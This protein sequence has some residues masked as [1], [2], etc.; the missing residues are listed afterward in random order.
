MQSGL[1]VTHSW[2]VAA[3]VRLGRNDEARAVAR[4]VLALQP[5]F[6]ASRFCAAIGATEVVTEALTETWREAGLPP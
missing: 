1:S 5:S 3:L 4:Q 6:S 2:L